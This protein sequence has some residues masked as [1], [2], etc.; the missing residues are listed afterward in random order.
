MITFDTLF[1]KLM[2][3]AELVFNGQITTEFFAAIPKP[4]KIFANRNL[5]ESFSLFFGHF[6]V[7]KTNIKCPRYTAPKI[8]AI[9]YLFEVVYIECPRYT[10]PKISTIG[11]LFEMADIERLRYIPRR[12]Y[13]RS[14]L[15][16]YCLNGRHRTSALYRFPRSIG[17]RYNGVAV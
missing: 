13:P 9:G 6:G 5:L 10:A 7:K 4:A 3:S 12:K 16:L 8:S 1:I 2:Q 17:P 15:F 14:D 11:S